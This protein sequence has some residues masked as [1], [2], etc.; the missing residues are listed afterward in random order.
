MNRSH[1]NPRTDLPAITYQPMNKPTNHHILGNL[2]L[3]WF[4]IPWVHISTSIRFSQCGLFTF[5][6]SIAF[7]PMSVIPQ[8]TSPSGWYFGIANEHWQVQLLEL[9]T[10]V[11]G[12]WGK[13][14]VLPLQQLIMRKQ[15]L[16]TLKRR[17]GNKQLIANRHMDLP[18]LYHHNIIWRDSG[19]RLM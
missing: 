11:S 9:F 7:L 1:I 16:R 19:S 14:V 8:E 2:S 15:L 5:Q 13:Y 4:T 17:F 18:K 3:E 10:R 6:L 12:I